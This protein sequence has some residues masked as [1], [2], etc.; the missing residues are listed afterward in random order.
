MKNWE[1]SLKLK[2][3]EKEALKQKSKEERKREIQEQLN[4]REVKKYHQ[5]IQ[6]VKNQSPARTTVHNSGSASEH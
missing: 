2:E 1:K 5:L 6:E 4:F 3:D